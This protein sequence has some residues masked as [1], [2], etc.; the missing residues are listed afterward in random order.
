MNYIERIKE[1]IAEQLSN[2]YEFYDYTT[3]IDIHFPTLESAL[4]FYSSYVRIDDNASHETEL[5]VERNSDIGLYDTRYDREGGI[6]QTRVDIY[7]NIF[8]ST[9]LALIDSWYDSFCYCY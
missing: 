3:R 5:Y 1:D 9:A 7:R 4:R 6:Y 2:S 8:Q